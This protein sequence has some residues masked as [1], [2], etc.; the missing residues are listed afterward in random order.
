MD[1][2]DITQQKPVHGLSC[3]RC[4][5]IVSIPEGQAIVCCP[6]CDMRSVVAAEPSSAE[7]ET[8]SAVAE[9][10]S[11]GANG[12]GRHGA[13]IR[14]G[15]RRYQAPARVGREQAVEAM[16][17][18]LSGK[19]QIARDAAEKAEISETFLVHLPFWAVWG[20]GMAWAFGQVRHGSGDDARYVPDEK[21]ALRELAWN[22][23][24]CDVGEF[25]V[26]E[27]SLD[28][29]PLEPFEPDALH[30][31]GMV[32]EP[33]GSVQSALQA[34]EEWFSEQIQSSVKLSRTAQIFSRLI[35]SRIGLVYY[36]LWVL[37][38]RY[39]GRSFQVVVDGVRGDVLYGK[40]PGSVGYRA[41]A[42][43]GGAAIGSLVAVD[44]PALSFMLSA[45]SDDDIGGLALVVF[46]IGLVILYM[47]YHAFRYG[48]HYEYHRYGGKRSKKAAAAVGSGTIGAEVI[49]QVAGISPDDLGGIRKAVQQL[50]DMK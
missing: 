2:M 12:G 16:R 40:A 33:V 11:D 18:F 22:M 1:T 21:K 27:I 47:G 31:T 37:R 29:C 32:F 39:H 8:P 42:L 19:F 6:Y 26:R 23:P 4:G 5:G 7:A 30:R 49:Q 24:A 20:R 36:P 48:E 9:T 34:A 43:V 28:G 13:S 50:E 45:D 3:P 14:R 10:P 17:R 15:A 38:Y 35:H 44:L 25:G 46:V 41:A